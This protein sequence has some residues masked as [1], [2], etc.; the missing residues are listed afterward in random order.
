MAADETHS[1]STRVEVDERVNIVFNL[2]LS[3]ITRRGIC[4]YAA[5]N[6]DLSERQTDRY[7]QEAN[8]EF[9][10]IASRDRELTFGKATARLEHLYARAIQN[11][12]YRQALAVEREIIALYGLHDIEIEEMKERIAALERIRNVQQ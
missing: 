8:D 12:E 3:G 1:K 7:I 2:I 4:Q 6:W 5:K 9:R 10:H 11:R